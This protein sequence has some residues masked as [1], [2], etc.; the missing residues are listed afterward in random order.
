MIQTCICGH[1]LCTITQYIPFFLW[2]RVDLIQHHDK[3]VCSDLTDDDA[4]R[5]LCLNALIDVNHEH[6]HIYNLRSAN[7]GLY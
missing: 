3:V 1:Y 5:C 6:D 2:D 4:F 7:D